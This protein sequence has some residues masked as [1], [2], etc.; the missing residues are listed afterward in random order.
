MTTQVA[1]AKH[2]TES[3]DKTRWIL[4]YVMFAVAEICASIVAWQTDGHNH[5][6]F[7]LS[8]GLPFIGLLPLVIARKAL[9]VYNKNPSFQID[10]DLRLDVSFRLWLL[11]TLSY[12]LLIIALVVTNLKGISG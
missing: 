7:H 1:S 11:V 10:P 9:S 5:L 12:G 4:A 6:S 2:L 8:F 3:D